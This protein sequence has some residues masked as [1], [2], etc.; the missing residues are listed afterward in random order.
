MTLCDNNVF[1]QRCEVRRDPTTAQTRPAVLVPVRA[2][3]ASMQV[4]PHGDTRG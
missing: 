1:P 4:K 3:T 2:E